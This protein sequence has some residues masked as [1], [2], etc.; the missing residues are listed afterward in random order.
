MKELP[1]FLLDHSLVGHLFH[2]NTTHAKHRKYKLMNISWGKSQYK[3][4]S[5][6]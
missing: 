5:T 1:A 6:Q 2:K 3:T 4:R